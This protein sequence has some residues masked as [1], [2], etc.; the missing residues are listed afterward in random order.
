MAPRWWTPGPS[1]RTTWPNACRWN[2]PRVAIGHIFPR[3]GDTMVTN[4]R[5]PILTLVEDTSPG[6]HDTLIAACD[7]WRYMLLGAGDD[8]DNCEDNLHNALDALGLKAPKTPSPWNMWM[9]IPVGADGSVS[10]EPGV[11]KPRRSRGAAGGD[12]HCARLLLLPAGYPPHQRR[13]LHAG[14]CRLRAALRAKTMA[15]NGIFL[16]DE[17]RMIRRHGARLR[18]QRASRPMPARGT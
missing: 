3:P 17:Q 4:K 8:H 14:R 1:T 16:T 11:R 5:R 10:F 18:R 9:N 6:V 2:I 13:R 7:R 12:G 15:G